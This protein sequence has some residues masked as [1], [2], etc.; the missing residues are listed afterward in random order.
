MPKQLQWTASP[1]GR[2]PTYLAVILSEVE[3]I[4]L[5]HPQ[6]LQSRREIPRPFD[7]A[8]GKTFARDNKD[9]VALFLARNFFVNR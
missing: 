8:Q 7:F 9:A 3:G 4:S 2:R 5:C 1:L 6:L